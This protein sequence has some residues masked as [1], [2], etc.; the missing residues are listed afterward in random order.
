VYGCR[1]GGEKE[2]EEEEEEA[3]A[4]EEEEEEVTG[5]P[6]EDCTGVTP[7]NS[8]CPGTAMGHM[9]SCGCTEAW[10]VEK[11]VTMIFGLV[12]RGRICGLCMCSLPA[13]LLFY[14][15]PLLILALCGPSGKFA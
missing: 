12:N 2:G 3:E 14:P 5:G 10:S 13:D 6:S 8:S 15:L 1:R 9:T 7:V 11:L 4:E